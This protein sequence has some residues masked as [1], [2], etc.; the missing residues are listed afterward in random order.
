MSQSLADMVWLQASGCWARIP[1]SK[2]PC[3]G[4]DYPRE[5]KRAKLSSLE[6]G[7]TEFV[8][9]KEVQ[10]R[11]PICLDT[12][13]FKEKA[14]ATPCMHHYHFRC[15]GRWIAGGKQDCPMCRCIMISI[16]HDIQDEKTFREEKLRPPSDANNKSFLL[17]LSEVLG[18]ADLLQRRSSSPQIRMESG[19][20]VDIP[21]ANRRSIT[22]RFT[23]RP[24][25]QERRSNRQGVRNRLVGSRP[26]SL[27]IQ[28][29]VY[30]TWDRHSTVQNQ[31]ERGESAN[32]QGG[33]LSADV[34]HGIDHEVLQWRRYIYEQNLWAVPLPSA[35]GAE[36]MLRHWVRRQ[37]RL[38]EWIDRELM[39]ILQTDDTTIVRSFVLGVL[40]AHGGTEALSAREPVVLL[41]PFLSEHS[42]HFW[43]ELNC[44]AFAPAYTI[45]TYDRLVDYRQRGAASDNHA[46]QESHQ[47]QSQ[48][49]Q[50]SSVRHGYSNSSRENLNRDETKS[51][52]ARER[53]R[54]WQPGD[55]L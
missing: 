45:E 2:P 33:R 31:F 5:P 52:N 53:W 21:G 13:G 25:Y 43:H 23:S 17:H 26:Y 8:D 29:Y 27:R 54:L 37:R 48:I 35:S 28:R 55:P 36:R 24:D 18:V 15:I 50:E 1:D 14:V 38:A 42:A 49:I 20:N 51:E 16:L 47:F 7:E 9:S 19:T 12:M 4:E 11:C 39:A 40:Q 46:D 41:E 22:R 6:E 30:A 3:R 44:F 32:T 10:E 34:E